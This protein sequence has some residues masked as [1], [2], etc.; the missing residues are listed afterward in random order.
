M[1]DARVHAEIARVAD[2]A[3][4]IL[5]GEGADYNPRQRQADRVLALDDDPAFVCS[6]QLA[7]RAEPCDKALMT[8]GAPTIVLL[9]GRELLAAIVM[10]GDHIRCPNLWPL[11]ARRTNPARLVQWLSYGQVL[12]HES[13]LVRRATAGLTRSLRSSARCSVVG[14]RER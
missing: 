4:R 3:D 12:H 7:F 2:A 13:P 6:L 5:V 10:V 9:A 8:P 11:N 14:P 1:S